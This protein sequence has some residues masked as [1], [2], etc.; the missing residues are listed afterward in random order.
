MRYGSN[1]QETS[2]TLKFKFLADQKNLQKQKPFGVV[3]NFERWFQMFVLRPDVTSINVRH[4]PRLTG[5]QMQVLFAFSL[6]LNSSWFLI[7]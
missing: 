5:V 6:F 4:I 2:K 1:A 7:V 3:K